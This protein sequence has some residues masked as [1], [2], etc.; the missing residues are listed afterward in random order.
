MSENNIPCEVIRDLLPLYADGLTNE[1]TNEA[2]LAHLKDCPECSKILEG[3]QMPVPSIAQ[4]EKKEIDYLKKNRK[5]NRRILA[6][7]VLAALLVA[8]L[9]LGIRTFMTGTELHGPTVASEVRVDG[10]HMSVTGTVIDSL[11]CISRVSFQEE[12]GTVNIRTKVVLPG[13]YHSGRFKAE[14]EA[15]QP[16]RRIYLDGSLIWAGGTEIRPFVSELFATQHPYIGSMPDNRDTANALNLP[17]FL[18]ETENELETAAEP[19]LWR[20]IVKRDL[21]DSYRDQ[22]ETDLRS[23]GAAMIGCIG[24]LSEVE[25]V[26]TLDRQTRTLKITEQDA[27]ALLGSD[28]KACYGDPAATQD[29][30]LRL[31]LERFGYSWNPEPAAP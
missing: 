19:Y 25:F 29:M 1:V 4:A 20:I 7:S 24:N 9:L 8:A 13:V 18:G 6:G 30:V 12:D 22:I 5:R 23:C 11:H 10:T 17:M 3:M 16:V 28:I 26:Y 15:A 21:P 14:Y 31:G 2:V 27:D